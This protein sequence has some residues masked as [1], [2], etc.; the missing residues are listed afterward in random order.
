MNGSN[1]LRRPI[2]FVFVS[3]LVT[4]IFVGFLLRFVLIAASPADASYTVGEIL[5]SLSV[6]FLSDL[7]M[8][9]LLCI[10]MAVIAPGLNT[11]KY[12]KPW[13]YLFGAL[14]WLAFIYSWMPFSIFKQYGGGAPMVARIFFGWKAISF[15]LRWLIARDPFG[16]AT[17]VGLCLV[18]DIHI[19]FALHLCR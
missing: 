15:S 1:V 8:G 11:W 9:V 2:P 3:F 5:R 4:Y 18:G 14:W 10:P 7:G 19:P 17:R 13:S 16:L 6:G 12:N